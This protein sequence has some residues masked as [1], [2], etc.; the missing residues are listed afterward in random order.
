MND[1]L[2]N[3]TVFGPDKGKGG[4][5]GKTDDKL[6][7]DLISIHNAENW[8]GMDGDSELSM[9]NKEQDQ[10][11]SAEESVLTTGIIKD[12][13]FSNFFVVVAHAQ[14]NYQMNC[15]L[16]TFLFWPSFR[17]ALNLRGSMFGFGSSPFRRM[18][19]R[20]ELSKGM[21]FRIRI[22]VKRYKIAHD[23]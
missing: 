7:T 15:S 13:G 18:W 21:L 10:L 22:Q 3:H 6:I 23:K 12:G 16:A 11:T 8:L 20:S 2:Y 19:I 17:S 1:P 5:I 9:F 14:C 4:I